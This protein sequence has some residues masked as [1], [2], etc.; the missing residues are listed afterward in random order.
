[1]A[2]ALAPAGRGGLAVTGGAAALAAVGG[3]DPRLALAAA[4]LALLALVAWLTLAERRQARR[5]PG[6]ARPT[7]EAAATARTVSGHPRCAWPGSPP[8][9]P[10]SRGAEILAL[11]GELRPGEIL[12][13]W[14]V[15]WI[16]DEWQ[17]AVRVGL[18]DAA[19]QPFEVEL[20]RLGPGLP[21]PA[22]AGEL[23]V[24]LLHTTGSAVTTEEHGLGAMALASWLEGVGAPAP[25]WLRPHR[26]SPG[27]AG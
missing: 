23:G 13:R 4:G 18:V 22:V 10:G 6:E 17:G 1:M 24:Y 27:G 16:G 3:A 12:A 7:P 15:A 9:A 8:P 5:A 20:R 2:A 11:F 26:A 19:G 21:P 14:S 25:A